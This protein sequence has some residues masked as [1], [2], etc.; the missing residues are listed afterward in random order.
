MR[1]G[2]APAHVRRL[3]A[4]LQPGVQEIGKNA[5]LMVSVMP[6][7]GRFPHAQLLEIVFVH[8]IDER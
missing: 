1:T 3:Y 7:C 5:Y 6:L 4:V 8:Y 2:A